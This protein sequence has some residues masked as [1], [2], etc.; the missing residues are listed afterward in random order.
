MLL[1]RNKGKDIDTKIHLYLFPYLQTRSR[2]VE[3]KEV[4][5]VWMLVSSSPSPYL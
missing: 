3:N 5:I 1:L 2:D 4:D